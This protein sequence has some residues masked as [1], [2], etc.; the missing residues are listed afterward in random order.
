[1]PRSRKKSHKI[2][3]AIIITVVS[4]AVL[5]GLATGAFFPVKKLNEVT[6]PATADQLYEKVQNYD[7]SN[8]HSEEIE[9]DIERLLKASLDEE[10]TDNYAKTLKA[11]AEYYYGLQKYYTAVTVFKE[12]E[13]YVINGD[14]LVYVSER[15]ADAYEK[16]GNSELAAKYQEQYDNLT[17][18]CAADDGPTEDAVEGESADE[19]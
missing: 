16:F 13:N 6:A 19:N 8:G 15:L 17:R 7:Y 4:V 11:K 9:S 12:L 14:D 2:I 18:K 5:A 10:T 3:K 1:M